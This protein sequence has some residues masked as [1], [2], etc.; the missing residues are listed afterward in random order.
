MLSFLL[1]FL[2]TTLAF[3]APLADETV[4]ANWN[5]ATNYGAGG[6]VVGFIVL[7]LDIIV[8]SESFILV[9]F[10][11]TD[12]RTV[13]VLKSNRPPMDKLR[14]CVLVFIFPFIGVLIYWLFSNRKAHNTY[15]PIS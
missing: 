5:T 9:M 6:G 1:Q 10:A 2:F 13:E 11:V 12:T 3:A 8:W 7:V 4:S 15:E 14:W